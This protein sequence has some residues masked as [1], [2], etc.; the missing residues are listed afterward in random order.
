MQI[1][2]NN[3]ILSFAHY[4]M[5][6]DYKV[7]PVSENVKRRYFI[8]HREDEYYMIELGALGSDEAGYGI[9]RIRNTDERERIS[10][11]IPIS[12]FDPAK[13]IEKS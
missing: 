2:S 5:T 1:E 10:E 3:E 13:G 11:I 8:A 6:S 7:N 12:E 9:Y 4:L